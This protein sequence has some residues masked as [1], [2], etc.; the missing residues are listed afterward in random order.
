LSSEPAK[1]HRIYRVTPHLITLFPWIPITGYE[2]YVSPY[3]CFG[4][5]V[6]LV[7]IGPRAAIPSLLQAIDEA[8]FHP[9]NIDYI[10][11][12]HI[13][14]DH[15][16]GI[17][18]AIKEMKNARVVAHSRAHHHLI[19]PTVIWK[20]SLDTLNEL[21]VNYGQIEPVPAERLVVAE[22]G[23]KIDLG[24]GLTLEILMTPGHATHHLSIFEPKERVLLAGDAVGSCPNGVIKLSTLAPFYMED[25]LS[26]LDKMIALN[27]EKLAYAHGGCYD[28]AMERLKGNKEK[29]LLWYD[30]ARM[31]AA[32]GKSPEE[33]VEVLRTKDESLSYLNDPNASDYQRNYSQL[34]KSMKGLMKVS[35]LTNR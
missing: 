18:T 33:I 20:A 29:L 28:G 5:K 22:E 15:A 17:G 26:S 16:G 32:A 12:T 24:S 14:I 27:P 34:V 11:L 13:H 10:I 7:D 31:E 19:D 3:L 8:G 30:T 25:Y 4:E 2:N 21:A 1:R 6:A 35:S 23:M 9:E